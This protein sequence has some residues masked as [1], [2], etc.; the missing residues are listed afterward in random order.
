MVFAEET[1]WRG[2][3]LARRWPGRVGV[4]IAFSEPLSHLLR[5]QR[6]L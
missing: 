5:G 4:Q 2:E 1:D 6:I 3:L